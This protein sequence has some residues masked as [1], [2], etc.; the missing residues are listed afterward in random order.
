MTA[1]VS[2]AQGELLG[3]VVPGVITPVQLYKADELRTEITMM[4]IAQAPLGG[5]NTADIVV[6]HDD[7]GADVYDIT[8]AVAAFTYDK[9]SAVGW[10]TATFQAQHAGG[11]IMIKPGGSLAVQTSTIDET[12]FTI[13]G[14]TETLAERVR[15]L[16]GR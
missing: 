4:I 11:G 15:G 9:T 3:R 2:H 8:T 16:E 10:L 5:N 6:F 13:Y 14:H 12:V 1:G 7:S